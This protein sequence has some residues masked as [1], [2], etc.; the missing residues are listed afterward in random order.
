[1][2]RNIQKAGC[3]IWDMRYGMKKEKKKGAGWKIWDVGIQGFGYWML[4]PGYKQPKAKGM[5]RIAEP[6]LGASYKDT[7]V[8]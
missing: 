7:V 4:D 8:G 5:E 3:A 6:A 2:S 1:L